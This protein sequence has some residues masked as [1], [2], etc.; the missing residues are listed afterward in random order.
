MDEAENLFED[1]IAKNFPKLGNTIQVPKAQ[2]IPNK[3]N[4]KKSIPRHNVIKIAKIKDRLL[5]AT[6]EMFPGGLVVKDTA[7]SLL[8]LGFDPWPGNSCMPWV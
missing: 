4:P 2:K 6:K 5:K 3:I 1:I 7:L 8:W